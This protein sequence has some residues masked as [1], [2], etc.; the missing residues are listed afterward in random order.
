MWVSS[1]DII[2][3]WFATC[4]GGTPSQLNIVN[5]T[6]AGVTT[7]GLWGGFAW[8][9]SIKWIFQE[10]P[11]GVSTWETQTVRS[12]LQWLSPAERKVK[13]AQSTL[14]SLTVSSQGESLLSGLISTNSQISW[15]VATSAQVPGPQ[16]GLGL[17]ILT[18]F[19][20]LPSAFPPHGPRAAPLCSS[21]RNSQPLPCTWLPPP[22]LRKETAFK[23]R[24]N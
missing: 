24:G 16:D 9:S 22:L 13:A 4:H 14:P 11:K 12:N 20:P 1:A 6:P 8:T 7:L 21:R 15:A 19:S 17:Q 10:R 3:S 18:A 23:G 2:L 5:S